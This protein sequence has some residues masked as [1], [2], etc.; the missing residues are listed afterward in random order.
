MYIG[1]GLMLNLVTTI[2]AAMKGAGVN[3]NFNTD[4]LLMKVARGKSGLAR[5]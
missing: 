2:T 4:D 3:L 1:A 5:A